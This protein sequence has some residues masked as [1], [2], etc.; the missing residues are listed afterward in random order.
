MKNL[1]KY[2]YTL[3]IMWVIVFSFLL[4]L[5]FQ[6]LPLASFLYFNA[7]VLYIADIAS[8][9]NNGG[10]LFDWRLTQ[11]PYLFPDI[12]IA[13]IMILLGINKLD[14]AVVYQ[15][16][17]PI[18][19]V[20]AVIAI[21]K[22]MAIKSLYP[23]LIIA[24]LGIASII[25][26]FQNGDI[27]A[28]IFLIGF[29][30]GVTL[31]IL[32]FILTFLLYLKYNNTFALVALFLV[33]FISGVSDSLFLII[34]GLAILFINA[35]SLK[36]NAKFGN[37]CR[38]L[39]IVWLCALIFAKIF[40]YINPFPQ[41]R[42]FL[43]KYLAMFPHLIL[44]AFKNFY[45]DLIEYSFKNISALYFLIV[46]IFA[47]LFNLKKLLL[48]LNSENLILESIFLN[49][50]CFVSLPLIIIIQIVFGLYDDIYSAR[51]WA[52]LI[53]LTILPLMVNFNYLKYSGK[54]LVISLN[55][56]F[57]V[58]ISFNY[59]NIMKAQTAKTPPVSH[60]SPFIECLST[61][62]NIG[63]E[64]ISDYWIARPIRMYSG[65]NIWVNPYLA[66]DFLFTNASNVARIRQSHPKHVIVGGSLAE[67]GV[68][69]RLGSP[70]SVFCAMTLNNG[71]GLKVFDYSN[72][73]EA[74]NLLKS[75]AN[76]AY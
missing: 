7:D 75:D 74:L 9:L 14:V 18:L 46:V 28:F 64:L 55:L 76:R 6:Y 47:T 68:R 21:M 8:Y 5:T 48:S 49:F 16:V 62:I 22:I 67:E 33:V 57:L 52:P 19:L 70:T 54:T 45:R 69:A 27:S 51:H 56:I 41:D 60:F 23:L 63:D 72:N 43:G 37:T 61:S 32:L 2:L 39:L 53:F 40:S 10:N 26:N 73:K 30:S 31:S 42:E 44:P 38:E 20:T 25:S 66:P 1:Y 11:A 36:I 59:M 17:Y 12:L 3:N 35:I 29:H 71:Y 24:T 13:R 50:I 34:T 65:E 4:L 15:V 58:L